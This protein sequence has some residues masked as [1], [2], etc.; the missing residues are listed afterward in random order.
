MEQTTAAQNMKTITIT[1][2]A[3][4][5]MSF[6]S[7]VSDGALNRLERWY[8]HVQGKVKGGSKGCAWILYEEAKELRDMIFDQLDEVQA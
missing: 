3:D 8:D 4:L 1:I 6:R 5:A 7:V 2:P